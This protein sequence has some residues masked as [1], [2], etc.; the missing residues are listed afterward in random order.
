MKQTVMFLVVLA[1]CLAVSGRVEA[2]VPYVTYYQP[3]TVYSPPVVYTPHAVYYAPAPAPVVYQPTAQVR[4]RYRP[5]LGGTVTR[6][7]YGYAPT[8]YAPAPVVYAY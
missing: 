8:Y 1:S 2:Q 5:I 6:V 4:T 3:V 7:R